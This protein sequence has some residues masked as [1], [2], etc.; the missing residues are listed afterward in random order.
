VVDSPVIFI[1]IGASVYPIFLREAGRCGTR[2]APD[3]GGRAFAI[4][5]PLESELAGIHYSSVD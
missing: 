5:V 4:P 2:S 3:G 1:V